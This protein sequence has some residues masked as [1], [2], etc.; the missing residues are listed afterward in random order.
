MSRIKY[1]KNPFV[2]EEGQ[3]YIEKNSCLEINAKKFGFLFRMNKSETKV[4]ILLLKAF[5]GN[6]SKDKVFISYDTANI[7]CNNINMKMVNKKMFYTGIN[8]MIKNDIIAR[9]SD[10]IGW[11]W[12]N[13]NVIR[14]K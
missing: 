7:T 1:E 8:F 5:S 14:K 13:N 9:A 4:F 11:Y 6:L 10:G 2:T 3:C 12:I